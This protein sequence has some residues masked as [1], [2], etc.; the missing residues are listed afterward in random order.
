MKKLSVLFILAESGIFFANKE[1]KVNAEQGENDVPM[2]AYLVD[3]EGKIIMDSDESTPIPSIS[4]EIKAKILEG[5]SEF[6]VGFG[7]KSATIEYKKDRKKVK[8]DLRVLPLRNFDEWNRFGFPGSAK[9]VTAIAPKGNSY[10][11]SP[12]VERI[13]RDK[14]SAKI[15]VEWNVTIKKD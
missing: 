6:E 8:Q 12:E 7:I 14:K 3:E 13:L 4:D 2:H 5:E 9:G 1:G 11:V 10:V 15:N